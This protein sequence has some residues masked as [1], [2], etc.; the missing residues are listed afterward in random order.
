MWG[1]GCVLLLISN[2]RCLTSIE[3][4]EI[5]PRPVYE[6]VSKK[7]RHRGGS[8]SHAEMRDF[9]AAKAERYCGPQSEPAN[10]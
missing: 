1:F 8:V 10:R 7:A 9:H 2:N 3:D 6:V 5:L 4:Q